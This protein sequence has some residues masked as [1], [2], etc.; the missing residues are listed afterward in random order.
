MHSAATYA[1]A[2]VHYGFEGYGAAGTVATKGSNAIL[3]A[4]NCRL[5]TATK[6]DKG[7]PGQGPAT[8]GIISPFCLWH[9]WVRNKRTI[10]HMCSFKY[11]MYIEPLWLL[12]SRTRSSSKRSCMIVNLCTMLKVKVIITALC[13]GTVLAQVPSGGTYYAPYSAEDETDRIRGGHPVPHPEIDNVVS[14]AVA[15]GGYVYPIPNDPRPVE[16]AVSDAKQQQD[17]ADD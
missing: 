14:A 7:S 11:S 2:P 3:S 8:N 6:I 17:R 4:N 1:H 9:Q 10:Q 16:D 12:T 5:K 15:P 13:F